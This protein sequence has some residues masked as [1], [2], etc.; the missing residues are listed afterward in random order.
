LRAKQSAQYRKV[1]LSLASNAMDP[2]IQ[3][4]RNC[5]PSTKRRT[6]GD[7]GEVL[8]CRGLL[9]EHHRETDSIMSNDNRK[10]VE[11]AIIA[12][13]AQAEVEGRCPLA[14]AEAAFPGTPAMVLGGCY[15][16]LQM[17]QEDAWW[18]AVERTIETVRSSAMLSSLPRP[19]E[20]GPDGDLRREGALMR[21]LGSLFGV[22]RPEGPPE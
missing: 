7:R 20:V 22:V 13:I 18:E 10:Q 21:V 2:G 12:V 9:P 8:A 16:E 11:A 19:S 14:A 4:R 15:A 6:I 3:G 17:A 5:T 1:S